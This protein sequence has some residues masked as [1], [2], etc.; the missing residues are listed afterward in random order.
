MTTTPPVRI[1]GL[2]KMYRLYEHPWDMLRELWHGHG[3]T[4]DFWALQDVSF[5]VNQGEVF[6]IIGRNGAGK[7]TLL[8][9]LAG[10]LDHT[11]GEV[12]VAGRISAIL[13]L[14]TGFHPDYT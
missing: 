5:D 14:G 13:E 4:K 2:G 6:G 7:S 10:T 8:R 11:L 1:T 3:Q 12:Q 9:I